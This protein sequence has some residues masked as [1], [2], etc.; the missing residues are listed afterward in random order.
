M[1]THI[2]THTHTHTHSLVYLWLWE[3]ETLQQ[4]YCSGSAVTL[5]VIKLEDVGVVIESS[6][7]SYV[8]TRCIYLQLGFSTLFIPKITPYYSFILLNFNP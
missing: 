8:D 7:G 3:W 4:W 6:P 2:H 5:N 1:H